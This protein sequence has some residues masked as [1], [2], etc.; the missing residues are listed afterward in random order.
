VRLAEAEVSRARQRAPDAT[1]KIQDQGRERQGCCQNPLEAST[2]PPCHFSTPPRVITFSALNLLFSPHI[3][4]LPFSLWPLK[5]RSGKVNGS[6]MPLS[7]L[8]AWAGSLHF[9][10]SLPPQLNISSPFAPVSHTHPP[11]AAPNSTVKSPC[12]SRLSRMYL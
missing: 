4:L 2:S 8:P 5:L 6:N 11:F 1:S 9:F 12:R 10:E 7:R 3:S